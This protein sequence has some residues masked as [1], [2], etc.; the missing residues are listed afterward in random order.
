M[1]SDQSHFYLVSNPSGTPQEGDPETENSKKT[2]KLEPYS[3]LITVLLTKGS[4]F[5]TISQILKT[6]FDLRTSPANIHS[7]IKTRRKRALKEYTYNAIQAL[8]TL[9]IFTTG[10]RPTYEQLIEDL[11][12]PETIPSLYEP[13]YQE[14]QQLLT[15]GNLSYINRRKY[16]T[17]FQNMITHWFN[18]PT[19]IKN[20][21]TE[22]LHHNTP[23]S[24]HYFLKNHISKPERA[25]PEYF[26]IP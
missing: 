20:Q 8:H 5:Q 3:E 18:L 24:V 23:N 15:D 14:V 11:L 22:T 6:Q 2:S 9:Y 13:L 26:Q 12:N 17:C 7:F 10:T 19:Q 16:E 21:I 1:P 4:S 25:K